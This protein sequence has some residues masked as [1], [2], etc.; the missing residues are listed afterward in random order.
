MC[1]E[2]CL[3]IGFR[4]FCYPNKCIMNVLKKNY[5]IKRIDKILGELE[6]KFGKVQGLKGGSY[7]NIPA[8]LEFGLC[9]L[10]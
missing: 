9:L 2:Y 8:K 4:V 7:V 10:A 6:P 3:C 5:C 1:P